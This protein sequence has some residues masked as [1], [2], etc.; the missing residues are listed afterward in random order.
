MTRL[1]SR[2]LPHVGFAVLFLAGA[3]GQSSKPRR[4][5]LTQLPELQIKA[6]PATRYLF[7]LHGQIIE[8][9][10]VHATDPKFGTYEYME[11]LKAFD[12]KGYTV[13]SEG[14]P[15]N[16][17]P[18]QYAIRLVGQ[19]KRLL[20]GGVPAEHITVVGASKGAIIGMLA[21]TA[22]R[23]R[24]LNFVLMSNCNDWVATH[25]QIDL[26]GNVLSIYDVN[27][28]MAKTCQ[29]FF[30]RASGLNRHKEVELK[31][32]TGHAILYKPLPE[33]VDLVDDWAKQPRT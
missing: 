31:I 21:S 3:F 11:I 30:D 23:N 32:G 7:Y 22:L 18:Q 12:A 4:A 25:F 1:F 29:P 2:L 27:D 5:D 17:D 13:V 28:G 14:R 16:T 19:I 20:D 24:D 6:D 10:G 9:L 33:W 15:R 26:F 8:E